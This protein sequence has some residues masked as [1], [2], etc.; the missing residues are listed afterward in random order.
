MKGDFY[1]NMNITKNNLFKNISTE[2]QKNMLYCFKTTTRTYT[3]GETICF[4]D[5][6]D[7]GIGIIEKG[8][9]S[10]IHGLT[11]GSQ[12]I[13]EQLNP[14]DIFG[15][16][17]YFYGNKENIWVEANSNCTV[18]Y[19]D[20]EHIVK[21]CSKACNHH[22][23]LVHNV[24]EMISTKTQSICE[25]LEVLSQRSIRERLMSYFEIL[26]SQTGSNTFELPFNM[27]VLADYLS[28]D[29]SAMSRELGKMRDDG[30]LEIKKK[31]ITLL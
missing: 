16:L 29:R 8:N 18:M 13:L 30:L 6:N 5:D 10:V 2:D 31:K 24:L 1:L 14:G 25:H 23:Q 27:T 7:Q 20:Y 26:S 11:N 17:F 12:T 4:F 28:V 9:A 19:F 3:S 22:S 21:R 15:Q